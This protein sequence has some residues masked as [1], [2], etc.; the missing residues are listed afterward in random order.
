M[1]QAKKKRGGNKR[2]MFIEPVKQIQLYIPV[3]RIVEYK[4]MMREVRMKW[5]A[6]EIAAL[7]LQ[8]HA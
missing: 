1:E 4:K 8:Q 7:Q 6:E 5:R 2:K 3:S